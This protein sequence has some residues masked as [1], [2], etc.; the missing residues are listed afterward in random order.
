MS[1]SAPIIWFCMAVALLQNWSRIELWLG[2]P[3]P[4]PPGTEKVVLYA[5][6]WCAYCAKTR[7]F[8]LEN[9]IA[10]QEWDVENSEQGRND[11]RLLRGHGVPIIVVDGSKVIRG[12]D[13]ESINEALG[14]SP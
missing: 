1:K 8:F 6:T 12:Y 5:T 11:Y 4:L 13:P 7:K 3:P 10:Y 2:P 9:K 14:R